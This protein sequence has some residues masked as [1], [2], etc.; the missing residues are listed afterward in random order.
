[1][2]RGNPDRKTFLAFIQVTGFSRTQLLE[3]KP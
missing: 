1:M 3:L 2:H